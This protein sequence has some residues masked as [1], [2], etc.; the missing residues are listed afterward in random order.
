MNTE[1][2]SHEACARRLRTA[3]DL[4]DSGI[5][6][7]RQQLRRTHPNATEEEIDERL[8]AWLKKRPGAEFGDAP[9]RPRSLP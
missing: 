9:G 5:L 1:D 2:Q 7:R 4:A 3:L 8:N 6:L